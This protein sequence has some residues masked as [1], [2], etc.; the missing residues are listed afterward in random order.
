M[1]KKRIPIPPDLA[2]EVM[3]ASDRTCCVC[4]EKGRKTEIHHIDADPSNNDRSNLAVVCKDHQSDAHTDHAFARNLTSDVIRLYNESWRAIVRGRLSP[5][6]DKSLSIEY[7]QQVLLEISLAP[8]KWKGHYMA[9]YPR[10]FRDTG[11][12]SAERGGDVWDMM[13]E[14]AVHR[15]SLEEWKKYAPL[16]D[17]AINAVISRLDG[18]LAAHGNAVPTSIKLAILRTVSQLEVERTVYFQMPQLPGIFGIEDTTFTARFTQTIRL[19]SSLSRLA[20]KERK[21]LEP[22]AEHGDVPDSA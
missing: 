18:I 9:L 6:G 16:F 5:G 20:D 19:L 1:A 22:N 17:G 8:H 10:H 21:A 12:S 11:Y 15:Y 7:P 13:S 3:F 4:R 2:A 14:V